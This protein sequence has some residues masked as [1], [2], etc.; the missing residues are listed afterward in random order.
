MVKVSCPSDMFL[1]LQNPNSTAKCVRGRWKPMKPACLTEKCKY[2]ECVSKQNGMNSVSVWFLADKKPCTIPSVD[3]GTFHGM[4]PDIMGENKYATVFLSPYETVQSGEL[5]GF[6]CETGFTINVRHIRS[7][8]LEAP[9]YYGNYSRDTLTWDATMANGVLP[10]SRNVQQLPAN[11]PTFPGRTIW[12]DSA[13]I[14]NI[15]NRY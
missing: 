11:C 2:L 4:S 5:I 12:W 9:P 13:D 10:P 3:H 15:P 8:S 7:I 6:S 14:P 1:N